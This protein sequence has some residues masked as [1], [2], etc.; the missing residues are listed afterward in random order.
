MPITDGFVSAPAASD[1]G[2]EV[3][4]SSGVPVNDNGVMILTPSASSI[5]SANDPGE[6]PFFGNLVPPVSLPASATPSITSETT[7][8]PTVDVENLLQK[9]FNNLTLHEKA[10][11]L[12][13]KSQY[14][15]SCDDSEAETENL[16]ENGAAKIGDNG[17]ACATARKQDSI[18]P[19]LADWQALCKA[20]GVVEDEMPVSIT[21]CK[22]VHPPPSQIPVI[23]RF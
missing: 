18:K 9:K 3:T 22:K 15:S 5:C 2:T 21:Q 13:R 12:V 20:V 10:R 14:S 23:H 19:S 4:T 16:T 6:V 11:A 1:A 8:M 7:A 17:G